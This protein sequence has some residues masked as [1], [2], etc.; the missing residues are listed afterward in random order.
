MA[1][2]I[3]KLSAI[4]LMSLSSP[5]YYGDGNGLYL[6]VS[7]SGTKSWI[8]RFSNG[9]KRREMG[10]GPLHTI[11]LDMAREKALECRRLLA[12][13]RDPIEAR[14]TT[15]TTPESLSPLSKPDEISPIQRDPALP[16][17]E[18]PDFMEKLIRREGRAARAMQ[19]AILTA[20][21]PGE[22][23]GALWTEIDLASKIWTVPAARRRAGTELRVPLSTA[24]VA[25]LQGLPHDR[26]TVFPGHTSSTLLS[27]MSLT[28]VLR[29]MERGDITID[30]FRS[31][32]RNW[33]AEASESAFEQQACEH[34]L[35]NG[36]PERG[37][38]LPQP[39][40]PF[41]KRILIFEAWGKYCMSRPGLPI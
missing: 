20:C 33:C 6:Q 12:V 16:W 11:S 29:R 1:R 22:V 40:N 41:A 25:L 8:F 31:T 24:A 26:A 23:R 2:P 36:P 18:V 30:G 38:A 14:D 34:H 10:L 32:F 15:K 37:M 39:H 17:Q 5:G 3:D 28:A 9:G 19:F 35:A 4:L 21:G 7:R 13:G 27:K